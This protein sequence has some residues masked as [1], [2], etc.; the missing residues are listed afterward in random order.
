MPPDILRFLI[1]YQV[2]YG[3]EEYPVKTNLTLTW[4]I[5]NKIWVMESFKMS[6]HSKIN[7]N[8]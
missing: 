5:L 4:Q 7:L 3:V 2:K 8:E 1:N 6:P